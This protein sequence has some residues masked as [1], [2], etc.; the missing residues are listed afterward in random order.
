MT[1]L[2][3]HLVSILGLL[4]LAVAVSFYY[5]AHKPIT[6]LLALN[7]AAAGWQAA[8]T[9]LIVSLA[10]ALGARLL[11]DIDLEP[12]GRVAFRAAL[13]LGMLSIAVLL[14]GAVVG[15]STIIALIITFGLAIWLRR[16]WAV[17]WRDW[18]ALPH[19][20]KQ[21]GKLGKSI[22]VGSSLIVLV[23][24]LVALAPPLKFDS[25]VYHLTMPRDYITAGKV[26]YLPGNTYWGFPQTA[27]MLYSW[28]LALGVKH[29][30]VMG[31][32][33]GVLTLV[34]IVGHV[35]Q[36]MGIRY[37]W[38]AAACLLAS[39]SL[40]SSLAW[41]YVD[42]PSMLMGWAF[43]V[44]MDLWLGTNAH[45]Y[46]AL[47]G[48]FSG[49]AF[50]TKYTAGIIFLTGIGILVWNMWKHGKWDWRVLL[51]YGLLASLF[52]FPW[53]LK[54]Y[55]A[56]GNPFYP[57]LT[58]AGTVTN[59]RLE[60]FQGHPVQGDWRDALFLPLR[61]TFMGI[62]NGHVGENG[63]GYEASLGPALLAFGSLAWLGW[64]AVAK[65]Q[66]MLTQT[67]VLV[68]TLGLLLWAVAGRFSGH[69]IRTHLYYSI[70]P[71]LGI[72]AAAGFSGLEK[73][74]L[75]GVR[76]GRIAGVLLVFVLGLNLVQL[77]T[78][79]VQMGSV[80]YLL[81]FQSERDY[82]NSNLGMYGLAMQRV[83]DLPEGSMALLLWE[84]R[85]YY[86]MP[87]CRSDETLD[88]WIDDYRKFGDSPHVLANWRQQGITHLLYF[89]AGADFIRGEDNRY[90]S[91]EWQALD[92][93]LAE[94][95]LLNAY[96]GAYLLY[97]IRP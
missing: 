32:M 35:G 5:Y 31:W 41:G 2:K 25:L 88:R 60:I 71:A 92:S 20:W 61:A 34:G 87:Q 89:Q 33:M 11:P 80:Q 10:G 78:G 16:D 1:S 84:A 50:G 3:S 18:A 64:A 21:S 27:H 67:A 23:G 86:C 81:G 40:A 13:G 68:G 14:L 38:V 91:A 63:P 69:L 74:V 93:L 4:W 52:A 7:L 75:P 19:A 44:S 22:A 54:N 76:L 30:A 47:A 51:R 55:L 90:L 95:E 49:M 57:L 36:R 8:V 24:F 96:N 43:V 28:G 15:L 53:L 72:L 42:W 73:R 62:E 6:P 58:A 85:G 59:T 37:G 83:Q 79:L 46:L 9:V 77:G 17:W 48:A 82:V 26:V 45:R 65:P 56:T 29:M 12:L 97:D 70:F 66:K 94:L 39:Y